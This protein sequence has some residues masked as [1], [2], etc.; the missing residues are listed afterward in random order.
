MHA[1]SFDEFLL[2]APIKRAISDCGFEHP[3]EGMLLLTRLAILDD[4]VAGWR[5]KNNNW[6]PQTPQSKT[7]V[8]HRQFSELTLFAKQRVEWEKPLYLW[9]PL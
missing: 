3:S 4:A 5:I 1:T 9:F 2:S 8:S 6:Q 7:S